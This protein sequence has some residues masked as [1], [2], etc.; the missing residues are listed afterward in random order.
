MPD[1]PSTSSGPLTPGDVYFSPSPSHED[2]DFDTIFTDGRTPVAISPNH[3]KNHPL[4]KPTGT[5][6]VLTFYPTMEEFRDFSRYIRVIEQKGAHLNAGIAKIVAPEGWTPRPSKKDFSDVDNYEITQPARETI[7]AMEKPGAFFK[8]NVTCRRKMPAREFRDMALS[9]QYRNPKPNLEGID[10]EKHYF[11]NI[12]EGEPIYG[13]DTEGSFYDKETNEFNMNRLGTLLD[14]TNLKIKGVNTVYLYFGMYKTTFPWHAEDM[15]LYSINF[16]HFGAP[17]YWFAISSEH[18]D[19]F[20][21][22]MSQQFPYHNEAHCKAFLRHKTFIVTPELLRSANIPYATMIQRPNE[23]IITFPRGYHMGFNLDYNLAESTNFATQRWIDYGKDA[24][25]CGCSKDSVKIDMAPFME[26][27]RPDEH[28]AWITYWYGD[29][30]S[31]WVPKKKET[32]KKR[33][34]AI[35]CVTPAKRARLAASD[36]SCSDGSSGCETEESS[37]MR[38]LPGYSMSNYQLRSDSDGM[39]RKYKTNTKEL[40][41]DRIDFFKERQYNSGRT[42]EWPHCS[43]CQYF[44]PLHMMAINETVPHS[45]RRLIPTSCFSKTSEEDEKDEVTFDRLLQCSNCEVTVHSKCCSGDQPNSDEKW[46]CP[47]CRNKTDVEIRTASCQLCQLRGGALIPCQIGKDSTWV[48]VICALFNRRAV[49]NNPDGPSA[50]F[51]EPSPRQQSET[52]S[53][54]PLPEEYRSEHGD[55]FEHS[56]WECV[57]CHRTDVGLIPCAHCIEED[58]PVIP[59]LAHITCARRVGFVCEVRDFPRGAVMICQK[60]EH[61][62]LINKSLQDYTNIKVGDNVYVEEEQ[63]S[64]GTKHFL[65]GKILR[66]DKKATVVVDFLDNSCSRDN[67]VEDIQSCECLYCENGDH[68]YGARVKVVWDD[69]KV[70]DAY[71]R[72]K[73][74]MSEYTIKLDGGPEVKCPRNKIKSKK[75]YKNSNKT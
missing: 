4:H 59:A 5:S 44:Q 56:R 65:S 37:F 69:K 58:K 27:Y 60:H 9:A 72:G 66:V 49:F 22:F 41:S 33:Q 18:A 71:F 63:C 43:V 39:L 51:V 48:H 68:Q 67:L 15:D 74:V 13:A 10:I 24:V 32:N 3:L 45:S 61:S 70:Y 75:E 38:S 55:M 21:R 2:D 28:S 73:G 8:R 40:R 26:M 34:R 6:E 11:Q 14:N 46:R 23:F 50:C 29:E 57:V 31:E 19:R 16:L 30:R 47:R 62:Y 54:P 20:E 64:S 35:P 7:E 1:E 42:P 12:L 53:M 17:K 52:S 36:G 25:L